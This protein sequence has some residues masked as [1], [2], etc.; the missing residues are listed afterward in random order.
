MAYLGV[1]MKYRLILDGI[2]FHESFNRPTVEQM[3]KQLIT[4]GIDESRLKVT[5]IMPNL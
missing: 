2:L 3:K 5:E 1:K 4:A